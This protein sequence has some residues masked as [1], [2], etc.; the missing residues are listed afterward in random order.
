MAEYSLSA[1]RA[2]KSL[3]GAKVEYY[4]VSAHCGSAPAST[5]PPSRSFRAESLKEARDSARA[6]ART[7]RH[8]TV[9]SCYTNPQVGM[10]HDELIVWRRGKCTSDE[11]RSLIGTEGQ[12]WQA[13]SRITE[14][15]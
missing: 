2:N 15:A 5:D 13:L 11:A 14:D 10:M 3:D 12:V 8:V 1:V 4:W 6:L 9:E 7:H